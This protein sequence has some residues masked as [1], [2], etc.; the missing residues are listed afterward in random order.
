MVDTWGLYYKT[1]YGRNRSRIA[2]V[3]VTA[4]HFHPS[5]IF[6]GKSGVP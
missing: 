4:I 2:R 3:L 1:F 5:L 6:V